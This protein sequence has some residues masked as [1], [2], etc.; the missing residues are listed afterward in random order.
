LR[1]G[2]Y[3]EVGLK[4]AREARE[5][6]K[7]VLAGGGDPMEV[8]KQAKAEQAIASANTFEAIAAE[9]VEKKR[10]EDKADQTISTEWLL[11]LAYPEI[12]ARP[13]KEITASDILRVLRTVAAR[14]RFESAKRLRATIGH[15][16]RYAVATGRADA[17]PTG[18][19]KGAIPSPPVPPCGDRRSEG[20]WRL[21][22]RDQRI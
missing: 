14:G 11:S 19:L 20:L 1:T 7:K 13:I 15:V 8:K 6:A 12:G 22:A 4:D 9:L 16:F 17:G 5:A 2:V 10:D 3:P 21:A 18:A